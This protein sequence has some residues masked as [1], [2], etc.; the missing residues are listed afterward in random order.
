M[1]KERKPGTERDKE[2]K[3]ARVAAFAFFSLIEL[4]DRVERRFTMRAFSLIVRK[5]PRGYAPSYVEVHKS[6]EAS[7]GFF[8]RAAKR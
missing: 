4:I 8:L 2:D 6:R 5:R 1:R 7:R 3:R